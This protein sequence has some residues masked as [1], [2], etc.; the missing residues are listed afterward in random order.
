MDIDPIPPLPPLPPAYRSQVTPSANDVGAFTQALFGTARQLPEDAAASHF[1]ES[2][3]RVDLAL[4]KAGDVPAITQSPIDM[5]QAQ[6]ALLRTVIEVDVIA[7]MAG[8]VSQSVNKLTNL[9]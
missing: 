2:S 6:S 9:Q 8:V 4:Q 1:Q 5:L 7:K 3:S